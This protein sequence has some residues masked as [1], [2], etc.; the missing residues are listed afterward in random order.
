VRIKFHRAIAVLALLAVAVGAI[1]N[2]N[3][4]SAFQSPIATP[5][6]WTQETPVT[7][8][9]SCDGPLPTPTSMELVKPA[10]PT[11]RVRQQ[12]DDDDDEDRPAITQPATPEPTPN[13]LE[14]IKSLP[15]T[16]S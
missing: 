15:V 9:P 16:G 10:V 5:E 1:M 8:T 2:Q 12:D 6:V 13:P 3:A 7:G 11:V 4:N 14:G